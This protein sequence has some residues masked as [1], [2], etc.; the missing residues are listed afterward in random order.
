M[1]KIVLMM[2]LTAMEM[3]TGNESQIELAIGTYGEHLHR[4]SFNT[5]T[6]TFT[7]TGKAEAVNPSYV[8]SENGMIFA[9]SETGAD[10]GIYTIEETDAKEG[11]AFEKTAHLR[12]TGAD[13][14]YLMLYDEGNKQYLMTA[15]YS[16]G[17]ISVFPLTEGIAKDRIA[18]LVFEG[19]GPVAGRQ[20]SSHIH[21]VKEVPG[22]KGYILASD[23]GADV[24]RL[25]KADAKDEAPYLELEHISDIPCPAGSGPRHMEFSLDGCNLYCITELGGEVLRYD[26]TSGNGIPEFTLVQRILADEVSAGG[27]ADIHIHPSG[28]WLYTSH[29]LDNDGI[30][31][32]TIKEDGTLVKTGY[33]RT[34][35]HPRNFLITPD[36][37]LL[38]AA[39]LN[40][41]VIQVFKIAQNGNLTLT[42]S[43]LHFESDRPSSV[44]VIR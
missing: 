43:A 17:S 11:K 2:A 25:I 23:L 34:A 7:Q 16:G 36:G 40:D 6:Y 21:Q 44:T 19:R 1:K 33:A 32:F 18:Q 41:G 30:A 9:V 5:Q 20:E 26:V 42:P 28:K 22:H 31:T 37:Q 12:Q 35:R 14:C 24:I 39:C 15:D 38:I 13:P 10:S 3:C 8:M 4:Y 29:R 27:S